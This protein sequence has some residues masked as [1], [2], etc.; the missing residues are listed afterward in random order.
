MLDVAQ[1]GSIAEISARRLEGEE[2][3]LGRYSGQ[4]LLVV[5]VASRCGF[6][7]QYA[8]LQ[9]LYSRYRDRGLVVLG[10]PC[11]QFLFQE[12]GSAEGIRRFC[13][14]NY[15]VEF[16]LFEKIKVRGRSQHPLYRLLTETPDDDGRAGAV[17]WNFEK[18]LVGRDG[19]P[20]RRFRSRIEPL[21]DEVVAAVEEALKG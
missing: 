9:T 7:P 17:R 3:S 20:R 1:P 2:E 19:R 18:F 8:G 21:S 15:R 12:P 4:V 6:T 10:F 5:N 16:P 11:N 14:D 13:T